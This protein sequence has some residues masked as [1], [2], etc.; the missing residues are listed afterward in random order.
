MV[1]RECGFTRNRFEDFYNCSVTVK[2]RKSVQESLE[3]Q[4]QG[5]II[6]DYM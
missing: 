1:C 6:P 3:K 4:L 5:E 2:E